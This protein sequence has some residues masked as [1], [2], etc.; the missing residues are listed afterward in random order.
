MA[1]ATTPLRAVIYARISEDRTGGGLGI[2]RQ[3][4]DC[5]ALA[6]RRGYQVTDVFS[7][8]D[9]SAYSGK[10]RPGYRQLLDA[11]SNARADV[12]LAWHAD[13]L[14]R[15]IRELEEYID[16][17]E[18][19]GIGTV[20]VQ[21]G[22]YD[23]N[24]SSG[25]MTARIIG[26]VSRQE[27]EH[28]AERIRRKTQELAM[29]GKWT[30]GLR[31]FGWRVLDGIPELDEKEAVVVRE[32]HS[33]VLAGFSLG[34]F[35]KLLNEQGV[36]TARG[37]SW[38]YA[39]LR[40]ML[41]RPRNAGLAE[42]KG[43]VVGTSEFPAIVE[44]HIWEATCAVLRDPAR[45]RSRTNKVKYLLAGIALCECLE[46]VK[47]GQIVD[48]KG[49]K[50]MIYRC[51]VS[52]PGHVS[53]RISL[54][55]EHVE[56]HVLYFLAKEAHRE[57]SAPINAEALAALRT[58]EAAHRERLNEAARLFADGSIDGQQLKELTKGI[59]TKLSAVQSK[60][61]ELAEANIRRQEVD[62]SAGIDWSDT[63]SAREWYELTV[64][65]KRAWIRDN[66]AIILHRHTVG[67][68]RVFDPGTVQIMLKDSPD[69]EIPASAVEQWREERK[70]WDSPEPY[71]LMIRR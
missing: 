12:V 17:S 10:A 40:Q 62:I 44:R 52:G 27:S 38:T 31:P 60:L 67:S 71:G 8:N 59:R 4:E 50:H 2:A 21:S 46:P 33:H 63:S 53:K 47:S 64:E 43:E 9:I 57:G 16:V 58:D 41:M 20:M 68:A 54:V 23:L 51:A 39:T 28:K 13:R 22:E 29:A 24:T 15:S 25:R 18:R 6:E 65:R 45:R 7:D 35:I 34:S 5:R 48:R 61:T 26:A 11:M 55:D 3:V 36:Q 32:A 70:T 66:F 42:W 56:R 37:G 1:S 14:T 69:M 49:N 30:G 19:S